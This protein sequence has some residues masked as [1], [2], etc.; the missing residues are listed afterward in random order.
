LF[1]IG[2]PFFSATFAT[3]DAGSIPKIG[4]PRFLKFCIWNENFT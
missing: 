3:L 4:M 1:I 2:I